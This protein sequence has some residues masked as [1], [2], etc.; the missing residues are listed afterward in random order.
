MELNTIKQKGTWG[1]TATA[2]NENF[3]KV[4][5]EVEKLN[6]STSRSKGLFPSENALKTQ[7]PRPN[8]GDWAVIGTS[9][10]GQIWRCETTGTWIN[11]GTT[12]GGTEV[13]LTGYATN[14][15]L[16]SANKRIDALE[17][18]VLTEA[19]YQ[20]ITSPNPDKFYYTYEEG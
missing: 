18:E 5:N 4:N 9:I 7:C 19:A 13:N 20:A 14:D 12:G 16:E 10:P 8:V 6:Y 2:L 11:T 15:A 1:D 3:A 17:P